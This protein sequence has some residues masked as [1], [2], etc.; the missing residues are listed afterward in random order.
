MAGRNGPEG[1]PMEL[2]QVFQS[3]YNKITKNEFPS[4][5]TYPSSHEAYQPDSRFFP[6]EARHQGK[7]EKPDERQWYGESPLYT[8]PSGYYPAAHPEQDWGGY[9][10]YQPTE[11]SHTLPYPEGGGGFSPAVGSVPYPRPAP[12]QA[13]QLDDALNILRNHVDRNQVDFSQ[14]PIIPT[15]IK[16]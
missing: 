3:S 4:S 16:K 13:Q 1:D 15:H 12:A 8:D 10:H 6:F 7:C 11:S 9:P 14:V 5:E 2:Y